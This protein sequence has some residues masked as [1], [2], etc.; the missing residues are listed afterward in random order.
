M[1]ACVDRSKAKEA[2]GREVGS[3]V[4]EV[5]TDKLGR[6]LKR[7][8]T[9]GYRNKGEMAIIDGTRPAEPIELED[10]PPANPE[11]EKSA[12]LTLEMPHRE[13]S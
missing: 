11:I 13:P 3:D 8:S 2:K 4:C 1:Y 6:G 5:S 10:T 9:G 7:L 12:T